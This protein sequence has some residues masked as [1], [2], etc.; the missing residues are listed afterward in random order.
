MRPHFILI[1]AF[2]LIAFAGELKSEK[3]LP[4]LK[5]AWV[6]DSL[7]KTPESVLWDAKNKVIYVSNL[8]LNPRIKDG[9]GSIGKINSKGEIINA[10]WVTGLS[11]PK[12]MTL[13]DNLL[14]VAD[15][16]ELVCININSGKIIKKI[17]VPNAKM[18]NDVTSD[19]KGVIYFSDTDG[20]AVYRLKNDSIT[21]ITNQGLSAPNGLLYDSGKLLLASAG[22][23]DF[24]E[25]NMT[26]GVKTLITKGIN[27]GDGIAKINKNEY[28]VSDWFGELFYIGP[29][30]SRHS[31][32][33]TSDQKINT[34]DIDYVASE[35]LLVVPTF[36]HNRIMAY[37][38]E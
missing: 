30:G 32:I 3:K 5:L 14:W 4:V 8:N 11:S 38:L 9:N 23:T 25:I 22:S 6:S 26:T 20:N 37:K 19:N 27:K 33:K 2:C 13:I 34:A 17:V 7:F 21:L 16:D 24:S 29:D 15:V 18:L 31:L 10:H 12:G 36:F 28:I 1:A 35:K